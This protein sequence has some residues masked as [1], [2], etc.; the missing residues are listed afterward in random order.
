[1]KDSAREVKKF[2]CAVLSR[3][4][5][6]WSDTQRGIKPWLPGKGAWQ[7]PFCMD[8]SVDCIYQGRQKGAEQLMRHWKRDVLA[9]RKAL[10]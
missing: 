2:P 7:Q 9:D 5:S 10:S 3:R 8:I 4:E 1:M 6:Q